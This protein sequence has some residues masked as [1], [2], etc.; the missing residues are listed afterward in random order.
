MNNLQ[1]IIANLNPSIWFD[2]ERLKSDGSTFANNDVIN[3]FYNVI[4]NSNF[5]GVFD[6]VGSVAPTFKTGGQNGIPYLDFVSANSNAIRIPTAISPYGTGERTIVFVI[7]TNTLTNNLFL[8]HQFGGTNAGNLAINFGFNLPSVSTYQAGVQ[9]TGRAP[10][11]H[12][13]TYI[14]IFSQKNGGTYQM[15]RVDNQINIMGQACTVNPDYNSTVANAGMSLGVRYRGVDKV[16]DTTFA[17]M[18]FYEMMVFPTQL[19]LEQ[20]RQV[21]SYLKQKYNI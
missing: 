7:W 5:N 3:Q 19:S 11:P 16:P 15:Y 20:V 9:L 18:Q 21:Q 1:K 4:G 12:R 6:I 17:S 2:T 13:N 10:S 8:Q 14:V